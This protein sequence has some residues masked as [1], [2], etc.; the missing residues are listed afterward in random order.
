MNAKTR[1]RVTAAG[2]LVTLGI[3]YGDIGTSPLYTMKTIVEDNG[4]LASVSRDLIFGAISLI[5]W[6]IMLLTTIKYVVIA[7]KA[8]NRGEGGIF[9]LYTLVR[10]RKRWLIVPALIGGAALLADGTLTPAVTVTTAV[11]GLKGMHFGSIIPISAQSEVVIVTMVVLLALFSIQRFGS[12]WI[13]KS[14]GPAM[15]V[16]FSFLGV[17][18]ILNIAGNI[19]ILQALNPYYAIHVLFSPD[20]K[21]G[22]FILGSVFLAT[23]GA[24]ALYSDLGHVGRF[25][26]YNT[27][28]FVFLTLTLNYLGQGAWI[29]NNRTATIA[30]LNPFF[31]IVP[32]PIRFPA[33]ILA[34]VAAIIASQALISGS[35]TLV[36]EAMRLKILPRFKV[37]YPTQHRGQLYMPSINWIIAAVTL[38]IVAFFQT[39]AH[40]EAAYGLAITVTMLMTTILLYQY[41][42][43]QNVKRVF[44]IGLVGFFGT[45]ETLFFIASLVKFIHGGYVTVIIAGVILLV[46]FIWHHGKYLRESEDYSVEY[47]SLYAYKDQLNKLAEDNNYDV[48]AQNLIF[49]V[50]V[51]NNTDIKKE[52]MYSILDKR[53]KRADIYWFV[54]VNVTDY[55]DTAEYSYEKFGEHVM[56]ININLGFRRNQ[57]INIYLRQIVNDLMK[58]KIVH[59]QPQKYTTIPNRQVGDFMFILI[60]EELSPESELKWFDKWVIQSRF[61]L[62]RVS[63]SQ[64]TWYGL[65]YSDVVDE[66]VPLQLGFRKH[67]KLRPIEREDNI[68]ENEIK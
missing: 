26:I 30:N 2:L 38:S 18:G 33:I 46:M 63:S 34:T 31:E 32:A 61:W 40:M 7:L 21:V 23:T 35:F 15:F 1:Q 10:K 8:D 14:F 68:S 22:I 59:K 43:M 41:L 4:G 6:T 51:K 37:L 54:S 19:E 24:E 65:D 58:N 28:P 56:L 13:G 12:E 52:I 42:R 60:H 67:I 9:A 29:I 64:K 25:N 16:W 62:E 17:I 45:L 53:P 44:A 49:L 48:Y 57:S 5:F 20:N 3:V 50:N 66:T 36:A 27:W 55:P 47:A 39:S 11:E